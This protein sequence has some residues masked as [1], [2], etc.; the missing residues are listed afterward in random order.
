MCIN[1][2]SQHIVQNYLESAWNAANQETQSRRHCATISRCIY[3]AHD[4]RI[5]CV[6]RKLKAFGRVECV[7][8]SGAR[9]F[10]SQWIKAIVF[11]RAQKSA[12]EMRCG[13][14]IV[15]GDLLKA[16][17]GYWMF[18]QPALW[19][20]DVFMKPFAAIFVRSRF[21]P[22]CTSALRSHNL[23]AHLIELYATSVGH[24]GASHLQL[25]DIVTKCACCVLWMLHLCW[26]SVERNEIMNWKWHN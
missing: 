12:V 2:F 26:A 4:K 16:V 14:N 8:K 5:D 20:G 19:H 1:K 7:R 15:A 18:V 3:I 23:I 21:E 6:N 17:C 22:L 25:S 13:G 9:A 11:T 10:S 24:R